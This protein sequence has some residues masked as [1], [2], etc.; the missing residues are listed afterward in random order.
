MI[1]LSQ[2]WLAVVPFAFAL[3]EGG[4]A[5]AFDFSLMGMIRNMGKVALVV[6]LILLIMSI[7]SIAI[8]VERYL[9]YSA[10]K[11]QSR[12]FATKVAQSLKNQKIDEAI[13]LSDKYKKSHL[14]MVVIDSNDSNS[15]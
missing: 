7:W 14:A 8:M 10:A 4:D 11:N 2:I 3:A 15:R 6:V 5:Q 9:T 1:L 13:S 12:E